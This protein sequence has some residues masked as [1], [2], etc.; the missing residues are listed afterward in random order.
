M[1]RV[2]GFK[3]SRVWGLSMVG[4]YVFWVLGFKVARVWGL[5]VGWGLQI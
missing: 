4:V 5:S 3:V 1:F 2:L